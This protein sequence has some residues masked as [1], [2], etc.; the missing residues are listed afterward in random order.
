MGPLQEQLKPAS[1]SYIVRSSLKKYIKN[2]KYKKYKKYTFQ[3]HP[4]SYN[5]VSQTSLR[6][7]RERGP[8]LFCFVCFVFVLFFCFCF[9]FVCLFFET[10]FLCVALA[11]LELTL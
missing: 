5:V 8:F 6:L 7:W 9:V 11:V 3:T 1:Y 4:F 10:G 2:K